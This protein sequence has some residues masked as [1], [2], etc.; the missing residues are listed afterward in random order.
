MRKRERE[1]RER[2]RERKKEERKGNGERNERKTKNKVHLDRDFLTEVSTG[3]PCGHG[4]LF[5]ED[6]SLASN[7]GWDGSEDLV[8]ATNKAQTTGRHKAS[9][10]RDVGHVLVDQLV[11]KSHILKDLNRN[12]GCQD[13][14]IEEE[15]KKEEVLSFVLLL[16]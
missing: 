13:I 3:P 10:V 16:L 5:V 14:I 9:A 12:L 6:D 2:K 11:K 7:G 4:D 8:T 1:R 15:R